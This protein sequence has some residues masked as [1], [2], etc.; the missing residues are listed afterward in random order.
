MR[1][2]ACQS[3]ERPEV[4][5]TRTLPDG[6]ISRRRRCK[7]CGHHFT[8]VERAAY[9]ELDVRKR[10][11][12]LVSFDETSLFN[13]INQATAKWHTSPQITSVITEVVRALRPAGVNEPIETRRIGELVLEQLK[14]LN[15]VSQ[16][17]FGLVFA[18]RRD[19]AEAGMKDARDVRRWL[20]EEYPRLAEERPLRNLS[21]VV[22][23]RTGKRERFDRDKIKTA[24]TI[25][26]KGRGTSEE[27]ERVSSD[28][29][30][31]VMRALGDQPI[32]TSG[33]I[34]AEVLRSLRTRDDVAYL[35]YAST[36]KRFASPLDYESEALA[37]ETQ[38]RSAAAE[39][40]TAAGG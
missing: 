5:E 25:A 37:L 2:P 1:C 35:R 17:R 7:G 16:I 21:E 23:A 39:R 27:I 15:E 28:V 10:D 32:V 24:A 11:G 20:L 36:I 4:R 29:A 18:G 3:E 14:R 26:F 19:R 40:G 34:A 6:T 9:G 13:S 31:N 33:Q 38:A 30:N 12:R 8:T 22:K